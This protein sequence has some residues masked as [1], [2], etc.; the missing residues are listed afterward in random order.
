MNPISSPPQNLGV[1]NGG[2]PPGV[3]RNSVFYP[4][5]GEST[6]SRRNDVVVSNPVAFSM[7]EQIVRKAL[8]DRTQNR[9]WSK[10]RPLGARRIQFNARLPKGLYII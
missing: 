3:L 6:W 8:A 7:K 1:A 9:L 2:L 4:E 10:R 5:D